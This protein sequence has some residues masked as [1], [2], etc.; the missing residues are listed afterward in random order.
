MCHY[1]RTRTG[2]SKRPSSKAAGKSKPEAYPLGY[3]EDFDA[4]RTMLAAFFSILLSF[5]DGFRG[6]FERMNPPIFHRA[7]Q[8]LIDQAMTIQQILPCEG[9]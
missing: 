7:I 9:C 8:R 1:G 2:C 4:P 3:V 6:N 5:I